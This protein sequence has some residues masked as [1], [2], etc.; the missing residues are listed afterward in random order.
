MKA[1]VVVLACVCLSSC[2]KLVSLVPDVPRAPL[3]KLELVMEEGDRITATTSSGTVEI[4]AGKGL[5]RT[6]T[7]DGESR[8]ATLWAR[9]ERWNGSLGAYFAGPGEHW[10]DHHGIRRGVLEE[11]QQ[12]FNGRAEA[13]AWIDG[14]SGDY[15]TVHSSQGLVV[16]FHKVPERKQLNVVVSQ[17]YIGGRKPSGL[18]GASDGKLHFDKRSSP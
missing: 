6:Y 11:G 5:M 16:S 17:I 18:P 13:I 9:R 14:Q 8:T 1:L 2:M 7:W 15:A 3:D 10:K 4:L 12:H